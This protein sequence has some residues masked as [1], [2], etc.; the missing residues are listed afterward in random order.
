MASNIFDR[1]TQTGQAVFCVIYQSN[2]SLISATEKEV[3]PASTPVMFQLHD[4]EPQLEKTT[5]FLSRIRM[6]VEQRQAPRGTQHAMKSLHS[7][8]CCCEEGISE[9]W[10]SNLTTAKPPGIIR[11]VC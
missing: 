9:E 7:F 5:P 3:R 2:R 6:A 4:C 1:C 8:S 11:M 10:C